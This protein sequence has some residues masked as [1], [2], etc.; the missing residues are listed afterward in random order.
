MFSA[1]NSDRT[2]C[3]VSVNGYPGSFFITRIELLPSGSRIPVYSSNLYITDYF[4][5]SHII[6]QWYFESD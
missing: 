4:L 1:L 5:K 6:F 3:T 2:T